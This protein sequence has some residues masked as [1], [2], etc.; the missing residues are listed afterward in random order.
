M[1]KIKKRKLL[2]ILF[3]IGFLV[4]LGSSAFVA[5]RFTHRRA[6][7]FPEP[8]PVVSWAKVEEH[9]F[10]TCD[11]EQIGAWLARG[12]PEK[13]CVL[14]LHGNE[15]S[16][17]GMLPVME[18]LAKADYTVLAI[19]FRAHGDSTGNLNDFGWSAR[20]DVATA[21]DFL[22]REF[23]GRPIYVVGRS[24]GA[25]AA[26]YA[27]KDLDGR[28]AGYFLEQPYRDLRSAVWNRLQNRLPWGLNGIAYGGLRIWAPAFLPVDIDRLSPAD[29][30]AD[31][32]EN[33]PIVIIAG[34]ADRHARLDEVKTLYHR[35]ESHA[36]LV[37]FEDAAHVSLD[38]YDPELYRSTLFEFIF[39]D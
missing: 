25:A 13:G 11:N 17:G 33:V 19:S 14:L 10:T 18:M 29:R 26:I 23:A 31:I 38:Q 15:S 32:P 20:R 7:P 5:W 27:A 9:R 37:V 16:R 35:V 3:L 28:I 21:V 39:T 22:E 1:L 8:P 6:P 34:S 36:K 30:I 24:L 2:G 12:K 4:W